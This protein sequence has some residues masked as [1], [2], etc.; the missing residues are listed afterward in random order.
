MKRPFF[1]RRRDEKKGFFSV[2]LHL[3]L[4]EERF[5]GIVG[6]CFILFLLSYYDC[7]SGEMVGGFER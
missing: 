2:L 3:V 6:V 5:G 4:R 7:Y 1:V